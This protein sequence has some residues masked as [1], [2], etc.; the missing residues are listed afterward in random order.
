MKNKLKEITDSTVTELL[1][2][3]II[4]PSNYFQCFDKHAKTID[5]DL[6]SEAF[7]KE[8]SELILDEF[9][10]INSYV[11]EAVKTIDEA[12]GVTLEAQKAIKDNNTLVL[13]NLYTQIKTLQTELQEITDNVY[14]DYLTKVYNKKWLYH[15]YLTK[16]A[17]FKEDNIII[18]VDVSDYEYI[19]DT[20][21]KLI[22]NNLLVFIANYLKNKLSEENLNF[23]ISRYLTSKFI[24]SVNS[25]DIGQLE[26]I[27]STIS[28]VLYNTTLKSNS[29]VMIKPTFDY[30]IRKVKK[31]QLFHEALDNLLKNIEEVK[32]S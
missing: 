18:L 9:N 23:N 8:L 32:K 12:A 11:N 26:T 4:L 22:S 14:K 3:E 16:E 2:N 17:T 10:E 29:G 27:M 6:D 13:K 19:A 15:K 20:Y 5:L 31:D 24:I 28:N 25:E 7:E 21:N 30:A 1:T